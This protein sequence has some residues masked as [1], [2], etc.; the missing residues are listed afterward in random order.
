MKAAECKGAQDHAKGER[1]M[2][3]DVMLDGTPTSIEKAVFTALL[4]NSIASTYAAYSRGLERSSIGLSEL[5]DLARHGEI[6]YALF[7]APFPVVEAQIKAKTDKLLNGLTKETFSVNS[8][9]H[10]STWVDSRDHAFTAEQARSAQ[11][12]G[13]ALGAQPGSCLAECE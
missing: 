10:A 4:E 2:A 3:I 12:L 11:P 7:F 8:Q 1:F 6:P 13:R 5:I 9:A